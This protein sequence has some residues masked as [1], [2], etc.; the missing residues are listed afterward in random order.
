MLIRMSLPMVL[1]RFHLLFGFA[2]ALSLPSEFK[3][4]SL[5]DPKREECL[6]DAI[7][8]AFPLLKNGLPEFNFPPL[9]PT[10]I[11][12]MTIGEGHGSV[13]IRQ[14]YKNVELHGMSEVKVNSI[15]LE[16]AG[17]V[18]TLSLTGI[19]DKLRMEADYEIDG[20]VLLLSVHGKG[21]CVINLYN[22]TANP[23]I[24]SKQYE[25]NGTTY[26]RI[27]TFNASTN[28][29]KV[30]FHFENLFDG[31]EILGREVNNLINAEWEVVFGDVKPALDIA[32][33]AIFKR[34]ANIIYTKVPFYELFPK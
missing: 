7:Q 29:K 5:S 4:C 23:T 25:K 17:D 31:N 22:V 30:D 33:G 26:S 15:S 9:E 19:Y 11:E 13:D 20:R 27:E 6:R 12:S 21:R 16:E 28:P 32:L 2:A 24:I 34:I 1:H 18:A 14:T 3:R 10:R 8:H